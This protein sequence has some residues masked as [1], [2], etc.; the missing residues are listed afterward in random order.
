MSSVPKTRRLQLNR[1]GP[2]D[3]FVTSQL[4][5]NWDILDLHPGVAIGTS[6]ER[7]NL[8]W[9]ADQVGRLFYETNTR[10]YWFV[11]AFESG[12]PVWS[13]F[14][15]VGL[16]GRTVATTTFI[17]SSSNLSLGTNVVG[18]AVDVPPSGAPTALGG[19]ATGERAVR[20]DVSWFAVGSAAAQPAVLSLR[21]ITS[22][23]PTGLLV[24]TFRCL[25][26][27]GGAFTFYDTLQNTTSALESR[28]YQLRLSSATD[29]QQTTLVGSSDNPIT[30]SATEV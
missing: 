11:S 19:G 25:Q 23:A 6:T 17:S 18:A 3:L 2:T 14:G 26:G 21:R 9:G 20:V 15:P 1:P 12:A 7:G 13:R 22:A 29:E 8:Q 30:I 24:Q 5:D 10:L 28:T 4:S 27:S 16:L